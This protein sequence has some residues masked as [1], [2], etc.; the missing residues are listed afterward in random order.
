MFADEGGRCTLLAEGLVFETEELE[1]ILDMGI[2]ESESFAKQY[3]S[4]FKNNCL[5]EMWSGSEEGSYARLIDC[6]ITQL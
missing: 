6:C 1:A 5:V 4:R 3:I 2:L